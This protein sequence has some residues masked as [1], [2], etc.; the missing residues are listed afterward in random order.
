ML[1]YENYECV[2]MHIQYF[3]L[4]VD[5]RCRVECKRKNYQYTKRI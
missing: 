4:E 3:M 5:D 1:Y 2:K